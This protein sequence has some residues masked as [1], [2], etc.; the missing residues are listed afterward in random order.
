MSGDSSAAGPSSEPPGLFAGDATA[1]A[2]FYDTAMVPGLF[3]PWA[4]DLVGRVPLG[5]GQRVLDVACGTG[6]LAAA[7]ASR[8]VDGGGGVLGTDFAPAMVARAE[9]KRIA[10]A[11]FRVGDAVAQ[12]VSDAEFDGVT[13]QQGLQFIPDRLGAMREMRRALRDGGWLAVS[14][15]SQIG[16]QPPF[17]AFATALAGRGWT[18]EAAAIG[19]PFSL[20]DPGDLVALAEQAGFGEIRIQTVTLQVVLPPARVWADGYAHVPPFA[21]AYQAATPEDREAF[22]SHVE[23]QLSAFATASGVAAPM[24]S[25]ILLASAQ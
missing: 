24:T 18:V 14:C 22:L 13:C 19:V 12:P 20:F 1:M 25:N 16:E 6:V 8:L 2:E 3:T 10:G 9:A 17:A 21:G 15:W 4:E 7:L 11:T 23:N 5:A